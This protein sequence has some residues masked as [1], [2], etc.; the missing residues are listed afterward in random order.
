VKNDWAD[1]DNWGNLK[2][3]KVNPSDNFFTGANSVPT[4]QKKDAFNFD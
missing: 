3:S 1:N 2:P 4:N